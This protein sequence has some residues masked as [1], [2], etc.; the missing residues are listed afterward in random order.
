MRRFSSVSIVQ[1]VKLLKQICGSV[2]V[3]RKMKMSKDMKT[4]ASIME[5]RRTHLPQE[6]EG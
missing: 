5:N 4:K 6:L 1:Q 3:E 2:P